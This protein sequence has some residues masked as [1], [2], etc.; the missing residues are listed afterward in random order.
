VFSEKKA[1]QEK[2]TL[3][4]QYVPKSRKKVMFTH[5]NLNLMFEGFWKSAAVRNSRPNEPNLSE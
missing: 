3:S 2:S 4:L 5:T 1:L